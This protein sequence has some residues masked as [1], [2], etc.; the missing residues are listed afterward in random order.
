MSGVIYAVATLAVLGLVFGIILGYASKIFA[1][2]T[3]ERVEQITALL[4]GANCGGCGYAGCGNL[5]GAIVEGKALTSACPVCSKN[6]VAEI[7]K[8]MGIEPDENAVK[9][10]ARV[11]C[12]GYNNISAKLKYSYDGVTDCVSAMKYANGT[13]FCDY[14]CIGLGTCIK[15]CKFGAIYIKDGVAVVD[16]DKCVACGMCKEACPKNII[17]LIPYEKNIF[18]SCRSYDKGAIMK[19]KCSAGCIGC[20]LCEKVCEY[21]AITVIENLA[22]IDYS[23]CTEC[24]KCVEKCPKKIIRIEN[25]SVC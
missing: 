23:K 13:K 3:D 22:R 10:A 7:S 5:A 1:V 25:K 4:P 8:I 24:G 17:D 20:K 2:E 16:K 6:A 9:Y 14:G 18:V 15:A 19:E 21:G 11:L 12:S